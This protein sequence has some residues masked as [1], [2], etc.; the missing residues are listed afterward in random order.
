MR[1]MKRKH[2]T[3]K[4]SLQH[5]RLFFDKDVYYFNDLTGKVEAVEHNV[6]GNDDGND[7]I[8]KKSSGRRRLQKS[9]S[10]DASLNSMPEGSSIYGSAPE[11]PQKSPRSPVK[12]YNGSSPSTPSGRP[13]TQQH[14]GQTTNTNGNSDKNNS[15]SNAANNNNNNEDDDQLVDYTDVGSLSP[16]RRL[17]AIIPET[18]PE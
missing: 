9:Y 17:S 8:R 13:V 14:R 7:M 4:F 12:T 10:T 6:N 1:A 5:D 3:A 2:P 18:I 16:V 15:S 11:S